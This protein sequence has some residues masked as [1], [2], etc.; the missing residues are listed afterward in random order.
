MQSAWTLL[1]WGAEGWL[2]DIAY[3]VLVTV[4][5][6]LATLPVG[7]A[8]G[9]MVAIAKQSSEPSLRLAGN[10]LGQVTLPSLMGLVAAGLGAAGVL[11]GTALTVAGTLVLLRGVRLDSLD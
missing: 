11:A 6:A 2:D 8:I 9:F 5:L 7:L 10:R 4:S 1:S 3:G